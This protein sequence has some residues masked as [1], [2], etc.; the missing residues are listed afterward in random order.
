MKYI[1]Q[2][3]WNEFYNELDAEKRWKLFEDITLASEDDGVNELRKKL[4]QRRYT[5]NKR[6]GEYADQNLMEILMILTQKD[7]TKV[8]S[9]GGKKIVLRSLKSL[10]IEEIEMEDPLQKAALYWELRN[11]AKRY[12]ETTK[13][14]SYG[15]KFFGTTDA[16]ANEKYLKTAKDIRHLAYI[17]PQAFHLENEMEILSDALVDELKCFSEDAIAIYEKLSQKA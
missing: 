2:E 4:L 15:K 16:S 7:G 8:F 14:H 9:R 10:G 3:K 1:E 13:S 6:T 17:I 5:K 11:V 12:Y